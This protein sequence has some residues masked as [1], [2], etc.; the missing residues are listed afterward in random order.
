MWQLQ[1]GR[2]RRLIRTG[3]AGTGRE[4]D[5]HDE[6]IKGKC[7]CENED[8]D[9]A[10]E[11]LWLLRISPA[12]KIHNRSALDSTVGGLQCSPHTKQYQYATEKL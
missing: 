4:D 2:A 1:N 12:I 11:Q 3:L 6:T 8:K 5:A 10:H 7:F 9:H